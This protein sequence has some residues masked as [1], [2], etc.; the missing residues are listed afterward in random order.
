MIL[1]MCINTCVVLV[2]GCVSHLPVLYLFSNPCQAATHAKQLQATRT[3]AAF[4]TTTQ[5]LISHLKLW[6][7]QTNQPRPRNP[8]TVNSC[9]WNS[10]K[11]ALEP[12]SAVQ[13]SLSAAS[14]LFIIVF[15]N[16]STVCV[17][18]VSCK[19]LPRH[20]S[21][22]PLTIPLFPSQV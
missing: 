3:L 18:T 9:P 1:T 7:P 10:F 2:L 14:L 16:Y 13:S 4:K 6:V 17:C 5:L 8:V 12:H 11:K 21:T 22:S 20:R 15:N 19:C